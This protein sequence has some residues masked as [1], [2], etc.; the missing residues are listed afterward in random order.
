MAMRCTISQH[1]VFKT[2]EWIFYIGLSIVS[3]WFASGVVLQFFSHKTNF[4]LLEGKVTHYPVV[5][6][7]LSRKASEVKIE[8]LEIWYKTTGMT[9]LTDDKGYKLEIEQNELHNERYNKTEKVLLD[10]PQ[11][12]DGKKVFRIIHTTPILTK[13]RPSITI[14]IRQNVKNK[15]VSKYSDLVILEITSPQNSPGFVYIKWKDGEPLIHFMSKNTVMWF[16]IQPQI[17]KYLEESHKCQRES[18]YEC[19]ASQLDEN[20]STECSEQCIPNAFSNLNKTYSK[21]FCQ[22]DKEN[23]FC[24]LKIIKNMM[25]EQE[26][27]SECKKSCFNLEYLGQSK[28]YR[29]DPPKDKNWDVYEFALTLVNEDFV[30]NEYE[31]YLIYD[32]IEMIGSVGG[33]LGILIYIY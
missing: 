4:S 26:E 7:V 31:E 19:L 1:V 23:E 13:T 22:N 30:S 2:V 20:V 24:A 6:M 11:R 10:S 25:Q 14:T 32:T 9:E 17:T 5:T 8:D 15:T 21:P 29:Q 27:G 3:G 28:Y 18:Y 12:F 33:T 16:D